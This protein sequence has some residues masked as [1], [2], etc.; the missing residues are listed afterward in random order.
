[1]PSAQSPTAQSPSAQSPS[2]PSPS[3]QPQERPHSPA[4]STVID[5][6]EQA[7]GLR[8]VPGSDNLGL[9]PQHR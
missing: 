2:A 1:S 4:R 3:A 8:I 7:E 9:P 5:A 6:G